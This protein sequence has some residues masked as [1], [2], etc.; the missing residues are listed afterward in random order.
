MY[1]VIINEV[2]TF[3]IIN[4]VKTFHCTFE[5]LPDYVYKRVTKDL[6]QGDELS[7]LDLPKEGYFTTVVKFDS[8]HCF[9]EFK[10]I[11]YL[12][13]DGVKCLDKL[14]PV[15]SDTLL[16]DIEDIPK[17]ITSMQ[18]GTYI[19]K[20]GYSDILNLNIKDVINQYE[21]RMRKDNL[22]RDSYIALKAA[23][24]YKEKIL[25][26]YNEYYTMLKMAI[27]LFLDKNKLLNN[28]YYIDENTGAKHKGTLLIEER[29]SE[30]NET[31]EP[32]IE[33]INFTSPITIFF[34]DE[35]G[36]ESLSYACDELANSNCNYFT[37]LEQIYNKYK[38]YLED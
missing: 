35:E 12:V 32:D 36:E 7:I 11:H 18:L 28:V 30:Y 10:K 21:I 5:A 29:N 4:E 1:T 34:K 2:K 16:T 13:K 20:D 17:D 9:Y 24:T 38:A 33:G 6:L 25:D 22:G 19:P 27:S 3:Q 26:A 15:I 37:V 8:K 14:T 23:M 31:H